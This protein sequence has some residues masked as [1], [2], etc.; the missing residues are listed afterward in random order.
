M[1]DDLVWNGRGL[2]GAMLKCIAATTNAWEECS[3]LPA[4][5]TCF[6]D[7]GLRSFHRISSGRVLASRQTA[8]ATTGDPTLVPERVLARS[9]K[10]WKSEV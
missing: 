8:P 10:G 2:S 3:H 9:A 5:Q 4:R 7:A 1:R 6:I